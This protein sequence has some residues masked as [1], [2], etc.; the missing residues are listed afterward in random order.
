MTTLKAFGNPD[1]AILASRTLKVVGVIIILSALVDMFILPIPYLWGERQWQVAVVAQIVDRGLVPLVG[2]ALLMAAYWI[3][4]TVSDR[5]GIDLRWPALILA[6]ILGLMYL[7]F[8]PLHLSNI[9]QSNTDVQQR[10]AQE[11]TQAEQQLNARLQAEVEQ[12]RS[13]ISQL[14]NAPEDQITQAA[15]ARIITEDQARQIREFKKNPASINPFLQQQADQLRGQLQGEINTRRE[16]A[17]QNSKNESLK[18]GLRVG[19]GTL[20]LAIAYII[21]SWTGLRSLMQS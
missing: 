19:I 7:I 12:K 5:K 9:S 3:D 21:I 20:L 2:L 17:L 10:I 13:Q 14:I 18:S 16:Q 8:F 6:A 15:Q 4:S 1:M 11:A